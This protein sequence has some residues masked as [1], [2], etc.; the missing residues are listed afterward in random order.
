MADWL[1]RLVG[2][3]HITPITCQHFKSVPVAQPDCTTPR[4][5]KLH[6]LFNDRS[7][8]GLLIRELDMVDERYSTLRIG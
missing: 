5:S 8:A 7:F 4:V 2:L 3:C 6:E 1:Q